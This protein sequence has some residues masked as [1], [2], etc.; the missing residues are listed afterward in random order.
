M[1]AGGDEQLATTIR[2]LCGYHGISVADLARR[3]GTNPHYLSNR[4]LGKIRW[5]SGDLRQMADALDVEPAVWFDAPENALK[6]L[7]TGSSKAPATDEV[8]AAEVVELTSEDY[9]VA[10]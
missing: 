6:Y 1:T 8:Q 5:N 10:V 2:V 7:R 4:M 9:P 3:I